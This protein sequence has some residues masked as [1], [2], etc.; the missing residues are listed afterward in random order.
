MKLRK[1]HLIFA[2]ECLSIVFAACSLVVLATIAI[3]SMHEPQ[4]GQ[5]GL[6]TPG[7]PIVTEETLEASQSANG[8]IPAENFPSLSYSAYR[9]REGDM[10]GKIAENFGI[11]Q[12]T[13]ISVNNIRATRLIQIGTYLKI[14]S[15]A[16][17]LYTVKKDGET[18]GDI[19]KKYEVSTEKCSAMNNLATDVSLSAGAS[20]F[21]PDAEMD[22]VTRQ[23]INGDLFKKP[24]KARWY[25]SSPYGWRASP[26]TGSRTY[27]GGVDMA[28]PQG[29]S[30]YAALPGKV[31]ATGYNNTYGNYVIITHHSGYKTLYGH[32]SAILA[33]CGQYV[34]Q[35]SK[36]GRVGSTGLSTGPHLH[37]TV[38]KNNKSVNPIKLWN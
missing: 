4:N 8:D 14:P 1:S 34:T 25:L 2:A 11:T 16:G 23:E 13:L 28:C 15:V 37:F 9:V 33:V 3:G 31:T 38:F 12:D 22:W 30:I 10:I 36:I 32:M 18:I 20:V 7:L 29:T 35:E 5:G 26:F 24:I 19:A 27:H 21:V 6:E 17:I